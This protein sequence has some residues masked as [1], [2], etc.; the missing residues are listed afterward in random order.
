M[1]C[2]PLGWLFEGADVCRQKD[3][4]AQVAVAA[5]ESK[6]SSECVDGGACRRAGKQRL[7]AWSSRFT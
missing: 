6:V 1:L 2:W 7:V 5:V 3:S 4:V